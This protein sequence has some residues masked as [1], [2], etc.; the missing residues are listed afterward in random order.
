VIDAFRKSREAKTAAEAKPESGPIAIVKPVSDI[1]PPPLEIRTLR[2]IHFGV[3]QV[4][5]VG[6]GNQR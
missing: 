3:V 6:A 5:P 1:P 4:E 2:G